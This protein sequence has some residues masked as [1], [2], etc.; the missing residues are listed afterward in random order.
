SAVMAPQERAA[1]FKFT[2][3][4]LQGGLLA[5]CIV[6]ALATSGFTLARQL[7]LALLAGACLSAALGLWELGESTAALTLL[8]YF[9]TQ[10]SLMEG[11]LRLSGTFAYA[12]IA[13]MYFEAV[14]PIA[15]LLAVGVGS[16]MHRRSAGLG[17]VMA[18]LLVATALILRTVGRP[19]AY[20]CCLSASCSHWCGGVGGP[21][22]CSGAHWWLVVWYWH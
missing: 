18:L 15:L 16:P 13:A 17:G 22:L 14:L 19:W 5:L 11:L 7:L 6:D 2:L 9:K 3:R 8:S 10:P 21:G 1:A 12:N 20:C 4:Q